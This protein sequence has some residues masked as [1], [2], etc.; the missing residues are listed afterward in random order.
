M[1]MEASLP[2]KLKLADTARPDLNHASLRRR[3]GSLG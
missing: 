2:E 3:K 1:L